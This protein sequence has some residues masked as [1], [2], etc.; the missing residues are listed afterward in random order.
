[1]KAKKEKTDSDYQEEQAVHDAKE[2]ADE[3]WYAGER[4]A[5]GEKDPVV[6]K[7]GMCVEEGCT[8]PQ[9][10]GARVACKEHI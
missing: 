2:K 3:E 10:A 7:S 8:N 9:V 4:K 6:K 1:M 5:K